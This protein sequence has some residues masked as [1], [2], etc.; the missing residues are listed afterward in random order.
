[1]T[2]LDT[3]SDIQKA[4]ISY[5]TSDLALI[6]REYKRKEAYKNEHNTKRN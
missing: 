5:Y 3:L 4:S 2:D 1:M 6:K